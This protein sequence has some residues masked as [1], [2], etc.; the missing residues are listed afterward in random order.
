MDLE[1]LPKYWEQI[2]KLLEQVYSLPDR[3]PNDLTARAFDESQ[4]AGSRV[5]IEAERYLNVAIDNH[6]A[7]M[8]LLKHHGVTLWAPWSLLRPIFESSFYAV[9]LLEPDDGRT[10]RLRAL[11]CEIRDAIEQ[12]NHQQ[13]FLAF[14]EVKLALQDQWRRSEQEGGATWTYRQEAKHLQISW[15]DAKRPIN[16]FDE[17]RR[18][19]VGGDPTNREVGIFLQ[20]VWRTLSGFEHG[21]GW[22]LIGNS[23]REMVAK[24]PGGVDMKLT[25]DDQA[26]VNTCKSTYLLFITGLQLF[27]RRWHKP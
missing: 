26:F 1:L 25:L 17:V 15:E 18:L 22:A 21:L 12:R 19:N 10:R 9:W 20:A 24:T 16:V 13:I 3:D 6:E 11:R 2:D 23:E 8:T 27:L 5:Y 7:L 14:P 4:V